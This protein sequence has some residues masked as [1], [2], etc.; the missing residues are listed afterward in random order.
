[1]N[2]PEKI[3]FIMAFKYNQR[4]SSADILTQLDISLIE[5]EAELDTLRQLGYVHTWKDGTWGLTTSGN[6]RRNR[7]VTSSSSDPTVTLA[8]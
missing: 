3:I 7:L 6:M 5:L 4:R 8:R 1:M 2:L